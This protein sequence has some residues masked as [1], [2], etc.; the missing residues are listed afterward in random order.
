[1]LRGDL[2]ELMLP[3]KFCCLESCHFSASNCVEEAEL[4]VSKPC[5]AAIC[6][7]M[8]EIANGEGPSTSSSDGV[9]R[10]GDNVVMDANGYKSLVTIKKG[11][12]VHYRLSSAPHTIALP[13][14]RLLAEK[15]ALPI[16][17]LVHEML[18]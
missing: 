12:Y 4:R 17:G 1:M 3:D 2:P 16:E 8:T 7:D 5:K 18:L 9:I 13:S 14:P 10:D 15:A 11:R 6:A